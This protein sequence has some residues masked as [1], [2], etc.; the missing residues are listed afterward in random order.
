MINNESLFFCPHYGAFDSSCSLYK[1]AF[2]RAFSPDDFFFSTNV[3]TKESTT[4]GFARGG[5]AQ[6][7][8]AC[9]R[10]M[11][12]ISNSV[13]IFLPSCS[14]L[15]NTLLWSTYPCY[16]KLLNLGFNLNTSLPQTNAVIWSSGLQ[17]HLTGN[18]L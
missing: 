9:K 12:I 3:F 13:H 18:A 6:G 2:D 1:G 17:K 14:I 16:V 5:G 11:E 7:R 15:F 4:R 10:V 8:G